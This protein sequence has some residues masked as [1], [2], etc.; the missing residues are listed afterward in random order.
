[1]YIYIDLTILLLSFQTDQTAQPLGATSLVVVPA[2][3]RLSIKMPQ[4]MKAAVRYGAVSVIS[5][6]VRFASVVFCKIW[7]RFGSVIY[8]SCRGSM[9]FRFSFQALS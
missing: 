5:K 8:F 9:R 4:F 7:V 6:T 1:M 3:F 2:F